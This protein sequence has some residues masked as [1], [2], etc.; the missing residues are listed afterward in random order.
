M[1]RL[2]NV[3]LNG[4]APSTVSYDAIN[5]V[6]VKSDVSATAY[7]YTTQQPG[8]SY[9]GLPTQP[10]AVRK[11][12]GAVFCYDADGNMVSRGGA[13]VTWYGYNLPQTINQSGGNYSTFYYAPDRSRY[14][15]T[16]KNG[17]TTEDRIYISGLFE[18][19]TTN[20][21]GVEYRHYVVANGAKVAVKV[22][23]A[24]RNDILYLHDDHLGSTQTITDSSGSVVTRESCDAWGNRRGNNWTGSPTTADWNAINTTTH[25]GFTG[26]EHLDNLGLIDLNGRVYDPAIG[27][28][29]SADPFIQ[30]PYRSQSLNRYSYTWN[31]PL[32]QTDPSGYASC[33]GSHIGFNDGDTCPDSDFQKAADWTGNSPSLAPVEV[34]VFKI[35]S[36]DGGNNS[37]SAEAIQ[38]AP[39]F[40]LSK[41]NEPDRKTITDDVRPDGGLTVGKDPHATL[42]TVEVKGKRHVTLTLSL[43]IYWS[44]AFGEAFVKSATDHALAE[45]NRHY[46]VGNKTVDEIKLTLTKVKNPDDADVIVGVCDPVGDCKT[47]NKDGDEFTTLGHTAR[48]NP[49]T[50]LLRLDKATDNVFAHELGHG[51]GLNHSWNKTEGL[52]SYYRGPDGQDWRTLSKSEL[53]RVMD[54]YRGIIQQRTSATQQADPK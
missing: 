48:G 45:W 40:A 47:T 53:S 8:C 13:A 20:G 31:N 6:N 16:S 21:T 12:S 14:R 46:N 7:D 54:A 43:T 23:S 28:F 27:R 30:A 17:A 44:A 38:S 15:Q 4:G 18:Q 52:M 11:A 9:A 29:M 2:Q 33:T 32:N 39:S 1:S 42:E 26:Q 50:M 3:S 22:I 49:R 25:I 35:G 19:L 36:M 37:D 34:S 51:L 41:S 10:H 24:T 5:N